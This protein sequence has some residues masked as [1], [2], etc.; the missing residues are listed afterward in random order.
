MM[1]GWAISID[2][3]NFAFIVDL[4]SGE[5]LWLKADSDSEI[6]FIKRG[7]HKF[8]FSVRKAPSFRSVIS[9]RQT[10]VVT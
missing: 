5:E 3:Y 7:C 8:T 9:A 1:G 2:G 10:E 6:E 4:G